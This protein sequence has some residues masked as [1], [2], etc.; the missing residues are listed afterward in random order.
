M[1]RFLKDCNIVK[2][3]YD[4]YL[5]CWEWVDYVTTRNEEFDEEDVYFERLVAGIDYE[6]IS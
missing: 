4:A 5:D 6:I 1:I 2:R 3:I